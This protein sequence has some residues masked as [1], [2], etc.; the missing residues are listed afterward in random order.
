M[1]RLMLTRNLKLWLRATALLSC[2]LM[3]S[4]SSYAWGS[5]DT[6][7]VSSFGTIIYG[8]ETLLF[9]DDFEQTTP[10]YPEHLSG[11]GWED[12]PHL[13]NTQPLKTP[14]LAGAFYDIV[15]DRVHSGTKSL[16]LELSDVTKNR[17]NQ[18]NIYSGELFG[19]AVYVSVWLFLPADWALYGSSKWYELANPCYGNDMTTR[20]HIYQREDGTFFWRL[21]NS[22]PGYDPQDIDVYNYD[23][24][25]P[26][27]RWFKLSYYVKR[28][29]EDGRCIV[30][31]DDKLLFDLSGNTGSPDQMYATVVAKIYH[32]QSDYTTHQLWV[33]DL[34]LHDTIL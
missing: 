12:I 7:S 30:W 29:I 11:G 25:L 32:T 27:G 4:I 14:H 33:D 6:K 19:D 10:D 28:G 34:E 2:L 22:P 16:Y 23:V 26:R 17:R 9:K 5:A 13:I 18:L 8:G 24:E 31:I 21:F 1:W 15:T 20:L 3:L